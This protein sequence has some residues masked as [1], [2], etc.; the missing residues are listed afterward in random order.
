M[1]FRQSSLGLVLALAVLAGAQTPESSAPAPAAI[2]KGRL[3][4]IKRTGPVG[5]ATLPDPD[6]LDGSSFDKEKRPLHGMLSE[7]EM[8]EEEGGK[9]SKVS[10][11]SGPAG[12]GAPSG[13]KPP[14]PGSSGSAGGAPAGEPPK[15]SQGGSSASVPEGPAAAAEGAQAESLQV[16]EGATAGAP[17][18]EGAKP[19]D[20]QIG[21][22]ALQIQTAKNNQ[23]AVGAV[24][25]TSQQYEKA[26]P[27]GGASSSPA[28]NR[29]GGVEKGRVIPKGL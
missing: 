27:K 15:D 28:S 8:G 9:N 23:S 19:R 20:L 5:K 25:S 10:P 26:L 7:I 14:P 6:L 13:Q 2:P 16:P 29:P 4:E 22:A 18:T 24:A 21:D 12:S 3:P 17:G 11:D 1:K